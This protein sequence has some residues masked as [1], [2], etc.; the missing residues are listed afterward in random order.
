VHPEGNPPSNHY[1]ETTNGSFN[2][3]LQ[4]TPEV[5]ELV[6]ELSRQV[7]EIEIFSIFYRRNGEH[8][9]FNS[10]KEHA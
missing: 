3:I 9:V 6:K 5:K 7:P 1:P 2:L 4:L 8:V 10:K